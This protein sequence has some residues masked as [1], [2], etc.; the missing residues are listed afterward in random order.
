[1]REN[2]RPLTDEEGGTNVS[3]QYKDYIKTNIVKC[4]KR[5]IIAPAIY[6]AFI[7]ILTFLSPIYSILRP[8]TLDGSIPIKDQ[9]SQN[10]YVNAELNNLYFTG[11]TKEW[12]AGTQGY[13][14]YTMINNDCVIVLLTPSTCEQGKSVIDSVN[15]KGKINKNSKTENDLF[16]R[17]ANDL[18]WNIEGIN[19]TISSYNISEPDTAGFIT[20]LLIV[21]TL[22]SGIIS[23]A[24]VL[25]YGLFILNPSIST[26]VLRLKA[27]GN[28]DK[29]LA[30]AEEE[31]AT[32]PQLATEDMYITEHFFIEVSLYGVAIVPISEIIWIYKYS[33]L[34]KILWHHFKISYTLHITATKRLY[35]KCPQNEKS[36]I[37]GVMEYLAEANHNILVGFSEEN[38]IKAEELSKI[39]RPS[40]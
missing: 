19:S 15:I 29:L 39:N 28:S 40:K 3:E 8:A 30:L 2:E 7:V 11:Y 18:S 37:D 34:H 26:P 5:K 6:L 4:Y 14:Y 9:Y 31:L 33:T 17:L 32:L 23:L 20:W 35:I 16:N 12:L 25:I 24:I 36:D 1:M 22:G 13:Y 38:R 27:Y 10:K 21:L